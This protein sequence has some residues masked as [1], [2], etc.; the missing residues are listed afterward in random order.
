M[1]ALSIRAVAHSSTTHD[2]SSIC[3]YLCYVLVDY[4][5]GSSDP[6][7]QPELPHIV[8]EVGGVESATSQLLACNFNSPLASRP[9]AVYANGT[10]QYD[11]NRDTTPQ[12]SIQLYSTSRT[13]SQHQASISPNPGSTAQTP[14]R[15]S[16]IE[17][18]S[19][20]YPGGTEF[21]S[22]TQTSPTI[23]LTNPNS[24]STSISATQ[25]AELWSWHIECETSAHGPRFVWYDR[26][27]FY[28]RT[29]IAIKP[30]SDAVTVAH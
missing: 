30:E 13:P 12:N 14:C 24:Y 17:L 9:N 23:D 20:D 4:A 10:A 22:P 19:M 26:G 3:F 21:P 25:K 18:G 6:S 29:K 8:M 27:K 15:D 5:C 1:R 28:T 7:H 16:S 11:P 2:A